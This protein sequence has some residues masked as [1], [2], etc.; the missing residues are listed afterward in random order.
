MDK[1]ALLDFMLG[2]LELRGDGAVDVLARVRRS[3][4]WYKAMEA[5]GGG[6]LL[7]SLV[8]DVGHL[9][10]DGEGFLFR[11]LGAY[12]EIPEASRELRLRYEN[13][14][15]NGLLR[16]PYARRARMA[17]QRDPSRDALIVRTIQCLLAPLLGPDSPGYAGAPRLNPVLLRELGLDGA[18]QFEARAASFEEWLGEPGF[19]LR[20]LRESLG[21]LLARGCCLEDE[22]LAEIEH[23][24][25][26]LGREDLRQAGRKIAHY[27]SRVP[28]ADRRLFPVSEEAPEVT[29]ELPDSGTYPKGGFSEVSTRGVPE[30]LVPS[31]L[32]YLGEGN[33]LGSSEAEIRSLRESQSGEGTPT[34][35]DL[36]A[37][38]F[39]SNQLLYYMRESG[40]L[41]RVRRTVHFVLEPDP[42]ARGEDQ[43]Y[44]GL[45]LKMPWLPDQ[46]IVI[47]LGLAVRLAQD[48]GLIFSGDALHFA[49]HILARSPGVRAAAEQDAQLLRVLLEHELKR[50]LVSVE[51]EG[52]FDL[53]TAPQR[54]RRV[55]GIC[56]QSGAQEPAG[57]PGSAPWPRGLGCS[58]LQLGG[59]D[60][61]ESLSGV[62]CV[63]LPVDDDFVERIAEA[64][65]Q[66]LA[67]ITG[68]QRRR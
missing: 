26:Y 52:R 45:R 59:D 56:V 16:D 12:S 18:T 21:R 50:G 15:L 24:D 19:F 61:S 67:E 23:W 40:E 65:D 37:Y 28:A 6:A 55:Y 32:I 4:I 30:N 13:G 8:H 54:G 14:F 5:R 34:V 66:L 17:I 57:L 33:I 47:L 53:R 51:V 27:A 20:A 58:V 25:A 60:D 36:F 63:R 7:Y 39:M 41:R 35:V 11:S 10:L 44:E 29:T 38:R 48:L 31:E 68:S 9:M 42:P 43:G 64:R 46:F 22:D 3:L 1:A 62:S 2:G 49:V